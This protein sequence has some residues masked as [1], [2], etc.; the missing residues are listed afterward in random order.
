MTALILVI[1]YKD[2]G[3]EH[4][5]N[6][7]HHYQLDIA[8]P[9]SQAAIGHIFIAFGFEASS[10]SQQSSCHEGEAAGTSDTC[11]V[12]SPQSPRVVP[13]MLAVLQTQPEGCRK[14]CQNLTDF[15]EAVGQ[16]L[17]TP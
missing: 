9:F 11:Q 3:E 2:G 7:S 13:V 8:G 14:R 16:S 1:Y 6:I 17:L 4:H 10:A 12:S 5:D 15:T